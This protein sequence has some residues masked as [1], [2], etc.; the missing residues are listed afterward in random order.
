ME[1]FQEWNQGPSQAFP[2]MIFFY[3]KSL[4]IR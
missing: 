2:E 4:T 3:I 1:I